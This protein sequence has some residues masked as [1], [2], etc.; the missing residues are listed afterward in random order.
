[1][2]LY[3]KIIVVFGT[4][5][6]NIVLDISIISPS[7]LKVWIFANKYWQKHFP[8][9]QY[10]ESVPKDIDACEDKYLPGIMTHTNIKA[11][12]SD[13]WRG[14]S[15]FFLCV[16]LTEKIYQKFVKLSTHQFKKYLLH[17]LSFCGAGW[18]N[19]K[20]YDQWIQ[21][22][23]H[24]KSKAYYW[25]ARMPGLPQFLHIA[26]KL[27]S[28]ADSQ[29]GTSHDFY[30]VYMKNFSFE[31]YVVWDLVWHWLTLQIW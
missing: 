19:G 1:M 10:F 23:W 20:Q 5:S 30:K 29:S 4:L 7:V 9:L 6:N 22:H 13:T 25:P 8:K 15:L 12:I 3:V 26:V 24:R 2:I 28:I 14:K 27:R 21:D 16:I 11:P 17:N 31:Y 18:Q